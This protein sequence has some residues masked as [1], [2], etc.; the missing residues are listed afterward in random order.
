M[1]DLVESNRRFPFLVCT[2]PKVLGMFSVYT[3]HT[4]LC[5]MSVK[6][7]G[8]GVTMEASSVKVLEV[9][10]CGSQLAVVQSWGS[11][12]YSFQYGM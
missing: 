5:S 8:Q 9:T 4:C 6:R 1:Q 11:L 7:V 12:E 2:F 3:C 10:W